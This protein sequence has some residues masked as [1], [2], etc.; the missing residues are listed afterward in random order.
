[1]LT[2]PMIAERLKIT[3]R[4]AEYLIS[5]GQIPSDITPAT[6]RRIITESHLSFY[7]AKSISVAEN[8]TVDYWA[9]HFDVSK[10]YIRRLLSQGIIEG[11]KMNT[12]EY[13]TVWVILDERMLK[14]RGLDELFIF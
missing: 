11:R 12:R 9:K 5:S 1:M 6:G 7:L 10:A 13:G 2:A 8:V 4:R 14:I 3:Q